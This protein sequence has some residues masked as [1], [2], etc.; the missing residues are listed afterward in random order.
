MRL[1]GGHSQGCMGY[2]LFFSSYDL[3]AFLVV[4]VADVVGVLWLTLGHINTLALGC[5]KDECF[6][7]VT[8]ASL[9]SKRC[10]GFQTYFHIRRQLNGQIAI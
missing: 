6:D 10:N 3:W 2:I 1:T 4:F 5:L 8:L 9:L 7:L